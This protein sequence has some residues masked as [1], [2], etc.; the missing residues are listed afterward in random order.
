MDGLMDTCDAIFSRRDRETRIKI[1]S[2]THTGAFAVM[3]CVFII[4]LRLGIF[5]EIFRS[6]GSKSFLLALASIPFW[7]RFG[8]A[9]LLNTLPFAKEGGLARTL[10]SARSPRHTPFLIINA[11]I[12]A[13]LLT[14][15]A[16][17]R[18]LVIPMT[19]AVIFF[20]WRRCC[21]NIFGGIAGDLLGTFAELSETAMLFALLFL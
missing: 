12:F 18:I 2:D 10:G 11:L 5:C 4:I 6:A 7:S 13:A 1:L 3:G 20:A 9:L 8:L 15:A 21:L 17:W 14:F 16:G 19:C